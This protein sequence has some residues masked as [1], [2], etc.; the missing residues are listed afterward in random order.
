M[1]ASTNG[2]HEPRP[3]SRVL[4]LGYYDGATDGV[5]ELG[6]GKV[7]RFDLTEE[8]HLVVGRDERTYTLRP[9][10]TDALDR[11][12]AVI[13]PFHQEPL[14]PAWAPLWTFP[15]EADD[16]RATAEV[17]AILN[18]ATNPIGRLTTADYWDF[19]SYRLELT[20]P[21]ASAG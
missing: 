16:D 10:P 18:E 20:T 2:V 21:L 7:Y 19:R 13:A 4:V 11:I 9:L 5:I 12:V 6:P 3:A 1:S 14:W 15:T 17:D 8:V